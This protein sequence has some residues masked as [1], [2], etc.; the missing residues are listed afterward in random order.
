M[1]LLT[2]D[3]T[4]FD[5]FLYTL[6]IAIPIILRHGDRQQKTVTLEDSAVQNSEWV[7]DADVY[8]TS[9]GKAVS[10]ELV[11]LNRV[12]YPAIAQPEVIPTLNAEIESSWNRV[13]ETVERNRPIIPMAIAPESSIT[14]HIPSDDQTPTDDLEVLSVP[15]LKA[16][17]KEL[18]YK[19]YSKCTKH[20]LILIIRGQN[21]G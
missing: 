11:K 14:V 1:E 3:L 8:F 15:Q 13:I 9:T 19:R 5:V 12:N 7:H 20:E 4:G 18:G 6:A 21:R 10:A 16:L 2:I 17:C